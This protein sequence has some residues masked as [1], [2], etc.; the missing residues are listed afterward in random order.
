[1]VQN[2]M[3]KV[4][5]KTFFFALPRVL[6]VNKNSKILFST[7]LPFTRFQFYNFDVFRMSIE[8]NLSCAKPV[9]NIA[10]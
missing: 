2:V 3:K 4:L 8:S 10:A 6:K 1:M 5:N 9:H 7:T